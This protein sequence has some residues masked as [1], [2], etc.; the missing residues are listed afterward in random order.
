MEKYCPIRERKR[1]I[2]NCMRVCLASE[3]KKRNSLIYLQK[4][5]Y[6]DGATGTVRNAA[7]N[8]NILNERSYVPAS[9]AN[10][11]FAIPML[12]VALSRVFRHDFHRLPV[13][14]VTEL[15]TGTS[16]CT[17]Q[18]IIIILYTSDII[19]FLPDTTR[20]VTSLRIISNERIRLFA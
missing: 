4:V 2:L 16:L 17:H 15:T 13:N 6:R 19:S 10:R 12:V 20:S 8:S 3:Q 11:V 5:E 18:Q 9:A 14:T 7:K 1:F